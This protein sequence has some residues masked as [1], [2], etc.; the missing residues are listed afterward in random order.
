VLVRSFAR[1]ECPWV[2]WSRS[3]RRLVTSTIDAEARQGDRRRGRGT[4]Q[5]VAVVRDRRSQV[6]KLRSYV[7]RGR[8]TARFGTLA[9][10]QPADTTERAGTVGKR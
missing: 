8:I 1:R 9:V 4:R 10:A 3:E 2:Y 5:E 6:H 7:G